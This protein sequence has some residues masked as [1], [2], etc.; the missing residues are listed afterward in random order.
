MKRSDVG[1][2]P[3]QAEI[4]KCSAFPLRASFDEKAVAIGGH[5]AFHEDMALVLTE[6]R[7]VDRGERIG[8]LDPE[9]C[10]GLHCGKPFGGS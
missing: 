5:L 3:P 9:P 10:P 8:G 1:K 7:D 2:V 4:A 6:G